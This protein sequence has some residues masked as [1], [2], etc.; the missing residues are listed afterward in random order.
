MG[1]PLHLSVAT[2]YVVTNLLATVFLAYF[3]L[4]VWRAGA[5]GIAT[6]TGLATAAATYVAVTYDFFPFSFDDEYR[7][8]FY[9]IAL[10]VWGGQ[11]ITYCYAYKAMREHNE[12]TGRV[13][14][15]TVST[16][17]QARGRPMARRQS[18]RHS[19]GPCVST[20]TSRRR[21]G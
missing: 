12:A 18:M 9:T 10:T 20:T 11:A 21:P 16:S 17:A 19:C 14:A 4:K 6:L 5:R 8:I 13:P 7:T 1:H 15:R 2:F 3:T